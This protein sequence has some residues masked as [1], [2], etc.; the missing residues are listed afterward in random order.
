MATFTAE[1][2]KF[3]AGQHQA[4]LTKSFLDG[5]KIEKDIFLEVK[6]A[7]D[8]RVKVH[9]LALSE[10]LGSLAITGV[11]ISDIKPLGEA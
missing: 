9:N 3:T 4:K 6:D 8:L 2:K 11:V 5:G 1:T 7:D 10:M